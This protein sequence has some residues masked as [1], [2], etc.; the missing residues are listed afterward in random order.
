MVAASFIDFFWSI[1]IIFFMFIYFMML[2]Q[3]IADVFRRDDA[4]GGK[5]ALWLIFLLVAPLLGLL[6]YMITNGDDMGR[7]NV[8]QMQKSQEAF[9]DYVRTTASSGGAAGEIEKAKGLL[10]SGAITQAE[11]ESIKT[12]ALAS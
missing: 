4:S 12:K 2:F 7:R 8:R 5:K 6:I 11:F 10:D 9:D 3:V 1:L